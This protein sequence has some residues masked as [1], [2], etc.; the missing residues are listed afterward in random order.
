MNTI[1]ITTSNSVIVKND[2]LFTRNVS[3]IIPATGDIIIFIID[4][5]VITTPKV[6]IEYPNCFAIVGKKP[7]I[8]P[9]P[10]QKN[11]FTKK[12]HAEYVFWSYYYVRVGA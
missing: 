1:E 7:I 11:K 6:V 12:L 2:V 4:I 10:V 5:K 3:T 8:G 9:I